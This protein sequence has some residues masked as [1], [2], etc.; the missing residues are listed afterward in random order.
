MKSIY[1][2]ILPL[3]LLVQF[4]SCTERIE[5]DL[6]EGT[7]RLVVEGSVTTDTMSHRVILTRTTS[8][9]FGKEAPVVSGAAVTITSGSKTVQLNEETPGVYVT[10]PYFFG[11]EG[12]T[13]TLG[14]RLASQ[15]GGYSEYSATSVISKA[16]KLDSAELV[17]HPDWSGE[18]LWEVRCSFMDHRTSDFYRFLVSRNGTLLSDTLDK[19]FVTDDRFFSGG[20]AA[21]TTVYLLDQGSDDER[22]EAGDEVMIEL[23]S[24]G[25]DYAGFIQDAQAELMGSNPLFSGPPANVK[26][27]ISNGAIGFFAAYTVSRV[28]VKV[29]GK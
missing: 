7:V 15:V 2:S 23:N 5:I 9:Y 27:N 8:Y 24:I 14:I 10:D 18:G 12:Q 29:T 21:G 3:L 28:R 1:K 11:V 16:V 26:G 17:F 4:I 25:R 20:Y 13:Y 19:W 22:L 6:D